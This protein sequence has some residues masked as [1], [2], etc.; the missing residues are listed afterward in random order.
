MNC[1]ILK[2]H[3][4]KLLRFRRDISRLCIFALMNLTRLLFP[5]SKMLHSS[6]SPTK[7]A[8]HFTLQ[9]PSHTTSLAFICI[10]IYFLFLP[11][12][13]DSSSSASF[14]ELPIPSDLSQEKFTPFYP[15]I[16]ILYPCYSP[17]LLSV[18]LKHYAIMFLINSH[19]TLKHPDK[20]IPFR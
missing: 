14:P 13:P 18:H 11:I 10:D 20:I 16:Y 1:S 5:Y 7:F 4:V 19:L 9:P 12:L 8:T 2:F 15:L 3:R 17:Y 6:L